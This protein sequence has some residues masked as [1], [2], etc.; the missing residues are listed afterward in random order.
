MSIM[1][2]ISAPRP[3]RRAFNPR[4]LFVLLLAAAAL[5][6]CA[7]YD[8]TLT[9]GGKVT[10]VRKPKFNKDGGYWSYIAANGVTNIIPA[11]RVVSVGPHEKTK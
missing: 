8:M 7:R 4:S 5:C 2:R 3:A 9:N 6:G 1:K 10:N 11:G